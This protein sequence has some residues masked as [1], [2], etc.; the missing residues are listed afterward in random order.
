MLEAKC[1]EEGD[2]ARYELMQEEIGIFTSTHLLHWLPMFVQTLQAQGDPFFAHV[3]RTTWE[4]VADHT[5]DIKPSFVKE[6]KQESDNGEMAR[7]ERGKMVE[8][9]EQ[10]VWPLKCGFYLSRDQMSDLGRKLDVPTGFIER[11]Q[12]MTNLLQTALRFDALPRLVN[13]LKQHSEQCRSFYAELSAEAGAVYN[14][15]EKQLNHRLNKTLD[16]LE[17]L[18]EMSRK[19]NVVQL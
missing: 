8:I 19:D 14:Q 2:Q 18:D 7:G 12:M 13:I 5:K 10:L 9:A 17:E 4:L 1:L 15:V 6:E 16:V 3:A 11:K